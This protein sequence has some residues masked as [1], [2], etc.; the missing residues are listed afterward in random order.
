M[1]APAAPSTADSR[2]RSIRLGERST[3]GYRSTQVLCEQR[4]R[5]FCL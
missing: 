4:S 3:D 2:S 5:R 1:N